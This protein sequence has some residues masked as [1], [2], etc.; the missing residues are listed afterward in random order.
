MS[1]SNHLTEI[2]G[3]LLAVLTSVVAWTWNK[4]HGR[5]ELAHKDIG[6]LKE[7]YTQCATELGTKQDATNATLVILID[8]MKG[9]HSRIDTLLLRDPRSR[10]RSTD[11]G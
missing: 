2:V 3:A 10:D 1:D 9:L 4:L 11:G 7:Q 6:S 8:D 5:V